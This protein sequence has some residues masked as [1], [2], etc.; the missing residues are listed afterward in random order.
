MWFR[1]LEI[2]DLRNL[3]RVSLTLCPGLNYFHGD[4]GAGKTALLEAVHLLAR[5]RSF[6]TQQSADLIRRGRNT[7]TVHASVQDEHRGEQTVGLSRSRRSRAELR[8]NGESGRRLSQVAEL[9]PL[10]V[11]GPELS[12]LVF[13]PPGGRRQWLD[14][15]VFH[16]E[17]DHLRVLREYLVAV[18]QRNA[19]LKSRSGRQSGDRELDVW[20]DELA[21]LAESVSANRT[22][23]LEQVAPLIADSLAR[24][25]PEFSVTLGYRQGWMDGQP[26]RKV[27]G[28]SVPREVKSG[29]TLFG[30]HRAEVE[31][32]IEGA[33]AATTLSRG[34]GKAVASAMM[35]AQARLLRRNAKRSSVFLIDDIGAELDLA[36]GAR[37]FGLLSE[38]DAQV[39]ATSNAGPGA[40]GA[41]PTAH[42]R[43]FHVEHGHVDDGAD[44]GP[45]GD[46][47]ADGPNDEESA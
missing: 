7:L 40:L 29:A 28:D 32:R 36:H 4:N 30:P 23:Y 17:H 9:L 20:S 26:L 3:E 45:G 35:L 33:A 38:L 14:W 19:V 43:T 34:Q 46:P 22:R 31:L 25:A 41:L 5:G 21:R 2:H 18:R 47:A 8:I 27:L 44:W 42:I 24:L 12:D 13:G 37:F 15:G 6:R 1:R 10:Q 11:M 16:V 39:L